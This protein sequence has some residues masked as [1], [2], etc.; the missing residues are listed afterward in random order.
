MKQA[1]IIQSFKELQYGELHL[2]Q[3]L[4][5]QFFAVIAIHSTHR[6]P[7]LGGCRFRSYDSPELAIVDALRL[8]QGMSYKAAISDLPFGGGKAVIMHLPNM[9][10]RKTIFETFGSFVHSLAGRYITAEDSGTGVAD[11]DIVFEKTPYVT[12]HSRL[13]FATKDPSPLTALG[14]VT[15]MESCVRFHL[16]KES[17]DGLHIAIQGVGNVGFHLAHDCLD[18]GAN[19]TVCDTNPAAIE[20]LLKT[21]KVQVCAPEEILSLVC[22]IFAPCAL[23]NAINPTSLTNLKAKI[24][25]GSANNQLSDPS[26]ATLLKEKNIL[27]APDYVINAGGLIH[28]AAQYLSQNEAEA[29][30]KVLKIHDSLSAIFEVAKAEHKTTLEIADRL[31]QERL[32]E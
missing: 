30:E 26:M 19:V 24:V 20:H 29:K 18:R 6:G 23:S 13:T 12:G 8:A 32:S 1:N 5:E 28:V 11:M 27:Y 3:L 31:A 7:A 25:A 22:D 9:K 14:V 21:A 17:L 10:D 15:G 4:S 2:K 16:K